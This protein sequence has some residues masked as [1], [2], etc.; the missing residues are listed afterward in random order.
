MS[1]T[2]KQDL[3]FDS[4]PEVSTQQPMSTS[5]SAEIPSGKEVE[6]PKKPGNPAWKKGMKSA[7]PH[8]RPKGSKNTM[9]EL[10]NE[11]IEKFAGDMRKDF[12]KVIKAVIKNAIGG[13]MTAAKLLLDRA[14]P[15][16]KAVEHYGTNETAGGI[17][18]VI[19]GT[20]ETD[21]TARRS[22]GTAV[23]DGEYEEIDEDE[24]PSEQ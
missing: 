5:G 9:T 17:T 15:A 22:H 20:E 7:N 23:V 19:S 12:D 18:I 1:S 24:R 6:A 3:K 14:I 10:Q 2:P 11:L 8:G 16:R 13:D 21:I 4:S